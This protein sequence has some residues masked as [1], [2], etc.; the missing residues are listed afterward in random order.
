MNSDSLIHKSS[1][2][3]S[4]KTIKR[5]SSL[6]RPKNLIKIVPI[7]TTLCNYK[8][9]YLYFDFLAGF[10]SGL[11][12]ITQG[13]GYAIIAN[14]PPINGLLSNIYGSIFYI[15]FG[16]VELLSAG[17]LSII[18]QIL[19]DQMLKLYP[20]SENTTEMHAV[21]ANRVANATVICFWVGV[22]HIVG[23]ILNLSYVLK[24]ISTPS[25]S[26]FIMGAVNR[27]VIE[28][29]T[30]CIFG[31][32]AIIAYA[33]CMP[34]YVCSLIFQKYKFNFLVKNVNYGSGI[35]SYF[36]FSTY[37]SPWRHY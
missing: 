13:I 11:L 14:L 3:C 4:R 17:N 21:Y 34:K 22:F 36:K 35:R 18:Q 28:N 30:N 2:T 6:W 23:S 16:Q 10:S 8:L 32:Y 19:G 31:A 5:N 24:F 15:I 26:G 25:S 7:L 37:S 20:D 9:K 1:K 33:P 12:S 27:A 29:F